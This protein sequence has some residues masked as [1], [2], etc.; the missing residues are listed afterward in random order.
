MFLSDPPHVSFDKDSLYRV[1]KGENMEIKCIVDSNPPYSSIWWETAEDATHLGKNLVFML[2]I[3]PM[4]TILLSEKT[5][6]S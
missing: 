2:R 5:I 4:K 3:Y 1:V 6:S